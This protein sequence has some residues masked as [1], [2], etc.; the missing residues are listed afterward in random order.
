MYLVGQPTFDTKATSFGGEVVLDWKANSVARVQLSYSY[1]DLD[2]DVPDLAPN[3]LTAYL[4]QNGAQHSGV[5]R[6]ILTLPGD[7][8]FDGVLRYADVTKSLPSYDGLVRATP[9]IFQMDVRLAWHPTSHWDFSVA[10]QNLLNNR[11][12]YNDGNDYAYSAKSQK[13]VIGRVRYNF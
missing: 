6:T 8:E 10:G 2:F 5:L 4:F 9:A 1:L 7:M 3:E 11:P 13:A 12:E